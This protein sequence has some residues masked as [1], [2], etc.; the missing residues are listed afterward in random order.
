MP[1]VNLRFRCREIPS[2]ELN[3]SKGAGA[4]SASANRYHHIEETRVRR[5]IVSSNR[6]SGRSFR[7]LSL[8]EQIHDADDR[9]AL[10]RPRWVGEKNLFPNTGD[11]TDLIEWHMPL[12]PAPIVKRNAVRF[13]RRS[14]CR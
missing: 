13:N 8:N 10:V 7:Y 5:F 2:G 14:R 3:S 6:D 12:V 4:V 11:A 1:V 9:V